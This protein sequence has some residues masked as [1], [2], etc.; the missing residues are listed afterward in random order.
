MNL[1]HVRIYVN[2]LSEYEIEEYKIYPRLIPLSFYR[3][4][5][6]LRNCRQTI[7]FIIYFSLKLK[8]YS[9]K[10]IMFISIFRSDENK[11]SFF[12]K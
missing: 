1:V 6:T 7:M 9:S 12:N 2:D 8:L 10:K 5:A 3:M 11:E 4:Y